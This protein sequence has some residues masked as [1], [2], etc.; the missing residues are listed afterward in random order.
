[1]QRCRYSWSFEHEVQEKHPNLL[2]RTSYRQEPSKLCWKITRTLK[3][4]LFVWNGMIIEKKD[5]MKGAE[6]PENT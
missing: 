6:R 1:M 5:E 2:K 3:G 4:G